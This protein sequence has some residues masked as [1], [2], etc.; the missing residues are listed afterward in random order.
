VYCQ[1]VY[2]RGCHPGRIRHVLADLP[3]TLDETYER[4]LREI[5]KA[6][7]ELAHRLFQC[8]VV[9]SRPL[10]V[11]ELAEFLAF[12]FEAGPIP[13]FREDWRLEDP[14]EAV[15]STCSTLLSL[16]NVNDSAVIQFSHFSV[17]EFLTSSRFADKCDTTSRRYHVSMTPANTLVA[18][19][20]L[21]ILLHLDENITRD[22]LV[23]FPLAK[24]AA[25]HWVEHARC[26]GAMENAEEGMKQLFNPRKSHLAVWLW[27]HDPIRPHERPEMPSPP[28]GTPLHYAAFCG[29]YTVANLLAIEHPQDVHSGDG[30]DTST[31]LHVAS[32]QGHVEVARVLLDHGACM[33]APDMYQRTPLHCASNHGHVDLTRFLLEQGANVSAKTPFWSTPLHLASSNGHFDLM[34]FLVSHGADV[35]AKDKVRR[36]PLHLLLCHYRRVDSDLVRF[37]VEHGADVSARD[38]DQL[39]PL[40]LVSEYGHDV[41][42]ARLLV[43]RGVDVSAKNKHENTPLHLASKLG[44]VNLARFLVENGAESSTKNKVQRTPLHLALEKNHVDL[45]W[46]LVEH[47]AD[48]SAKDKEL[49]TPLH[50]AL[51]YGH[52]DLARSLIEHGADVS[53]KDNSQRTPLHRASEHGHVDLA[54]ILIKR[55]ADV[56]AKDKDWSTPL[57]CASSG[58]HVDLARFLVENGADVSAKDK[59]RRTPLHFASSFGHGDLAEFLVDHSAETLRHSPTDPTAHMDMMHMVSIPI[60]ND[61]I[62]HVQ[63]LLHH[64]DQPVVREPGLLQ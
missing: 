2:L 23:K 43:E 54:R 40:H 36:T 53:A 62:V 59:N 46:V 42:L 22:S 5:K 41:D 16:I 20:C 33:T 56:S 60:G 14:V 32:K 19:A 45:A 7:S 13:K 37:L 8:V 28:C 47:G 6:D 9:A 57:H 27:I 61:S 34:R 11:E 48:A 4:A 51:T 17:K 29:L 55:G 18:Q 24:Y 12:D 31:P 50:Q 10:R 15:L 3:E 49:W 38:K 21:G 35:S 1:I 63:L 58:G 64:A 30:F 26:E 44:H 25:E 52:A 39:T